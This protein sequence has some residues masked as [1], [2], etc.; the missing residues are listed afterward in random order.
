LARELVLD[1]ID[2]IHGLLQKKT[3]VA[4][5][6]DPRKNPVQSVRVSRV[7]TCSWRASQAAGTFGTL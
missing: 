3:V 5:I 6:P 7:L 2:E 1:E 4:A